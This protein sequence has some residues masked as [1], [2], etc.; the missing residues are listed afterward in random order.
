MNYQRFEKLQK[1]YL[2]QPVEPS[3]Y[4]QG[5]SLGIA[6]YSSLA[7]C[8]GGGS[9]TDPEPVYF[10]RIIQK[11]YICEGYDKYTKYV[12][13][14]APYSDGPWNDV[15]PEEYFV[16]D[17]IEVNSTDCGYVAPDLFR[18]GKPLTLDSSFTN[19]LISAT[20]G[21]NENTNEIY[22]L[23]EICRRY[24]NSYIYKSGT[25]TV[26]F[27]GNLYYNDYI[28][29]PVSGK[30]FVKNQKVAAAAINY[31]TSANCLEW[32]NIGETQWHA[33][34]RFYEI[35]Y[36]GEE[37]NI[38]SCIQYA[39][40]KFLYILYRWEGGSRNNYYVGKVSMSFDDTPTAT[41]TQ[42]VKINPPS[43]T[44]VYGISF[45][46][47]NL[48]TQTAG[49]LTTLE[50]DE[51][52]FYNYILTIN[53]NSLTYNFINTGLNERKSED[54]EMI[55]YNSPKNYVYFNQHAYNITDNSLS[56]YI[57]YF[58]GQYTSDISPLLLELYGKTYYWS[59]DNPEK[60]NY[61]VK[62]QKRWVADTG[63]MCV[64]T[65]KYN[66]EKEQISYGNEDV[67]T[68]TGNTRA[69]STLIESDSFDCG[70]VAYRWVSDTGYMCAGYDKY[71]REKEQQTTD[72]IHWTDTGV[73]RAGSTLIEH[74][75]E[76]C[77][78]YSTDYFT[79][80]ALRNG[81]ISLKRGGSTSGQPLTNKQYSK[82]GGDW[83]DY[84]YNN[85]IPVVTGDKIRWKATI[86][87][88]DYEYY[89]YFYSTADYKVY[90]NPLSLL[91]NDRFV[92]EPDA[93]YEYA[94]YKLF[95]NSST[96][97]DVSNLA[98]S[99][100][101]LSNYCYGY[102][103][104]GC[105]S[106]TTT[107]KLPATKLARDCYEYMF[108]N[109]TSL[110]AAPALPATILADGCYENM[111][112]GCISLTSAPEL[113]ATTLE[114]FCYSYMFYGC[115]SLTTAPALPSTAL[116]Y[117]CYEHMFWNCTSLTAAPALP[118]TILADGCY[119]YMFYGCTSLTTVPSNMLPATR[120]NEWCYRC[121][122]DGCTSLTTAPKLPATILTNN[123][124]NGMFYNCTSLT[125][126]P[127]LPATSLATGCYYEMFTGCTSLNYIECLATDISA[128]NC[129]SIWVRNVASTGTFVKA[130]SMTSW[131]TG[132][133][134]IPTGW[135]V[136]DA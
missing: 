12:K 90:G 31:T 113:P 115:S 33:S 121:M 116:A 68:D 83:T 48:T 34:K 28:E 2:G 107:P 29:E 18:K 124:Y 65:D 23:S 98:L 135:T 32:R 67:W 19:S 6:D 42:V 38:G 10:Y 89:S 104:S 117:Y 136:Q 56:D 7:S 58:Y 53:T 73:T 77:A 125:T 132:V 61:A 49:C 105:T 71:N 46:T 64:G 26:D 70:Y 102:M 128:S 21:V 62:T 129:T 127:E 101:R 44:E 87:R 86:S 25:F 119:Y 55:L 63:Y 40:G 41:C 112:D 16:G 51:N 85:S 74:D 1:Y 59:S 76:D 133:S 131:K 96:L 66:K 130:P 5:S 79:T 69:G 92:D 82:N 122:F 78:H 52:R 3:I 95:E 37:Y 35:N 118:A 13:Q 111:F 106:L 9:G 11:G 72:G 91:R 4:K 110:T 81:Y 100:K 57:H 134:G 30:Y 88:I 97:K 8:E 39:F 80:E 36:N 120:L 109:C 15:V 103:F 60:Y 126:A 108:W 94:Y 47:Y 114:R 20:L 27:T 123:C 99:A 24:G 84:Y 50:Q 45:N 17:L 54:R 43:G 22:L 75:S 93:I 14:Y